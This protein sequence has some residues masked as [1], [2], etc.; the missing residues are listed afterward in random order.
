[1]YNSHIY[2]NEKIGK[3]NRLDNNK[4]LGKIILSSLKAFASH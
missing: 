3:K 2:Y 1:M 4:L